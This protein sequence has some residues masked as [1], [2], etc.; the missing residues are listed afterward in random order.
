M[1]TRLLAWLQR[2]S[3]AF[4]LSEP[5]IVQ[6]RYGAWLRIAPHESV[7]WFRTDWEAMN[8]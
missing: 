1:L 8:G 3:G 4:E 6:D 2:Q 7:R 5:L